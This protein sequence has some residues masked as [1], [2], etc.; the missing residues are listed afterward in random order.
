V[1][2]TVVL[3]HGAWHGAWCWEKVV[4]RL[5][6]AGVPA[7]AV[8]LPGH[9]KSAEPFGDLHDDAA[10]VRRLLDAAGGPV[11]LCG[12]SYGGMVITEAGDHPAV[13]HLV[14]LAAFM[15]D[16]GVALRGISRPPRPSGLSNAAVLGDDGLVRLG[17]GAAAAL[18]HDCDPADIEGALRRLGPHPAATFTQAPA[19]V[20]WHTVP[21]TYVVCTAD[22][23][24]PPDFQRAMAERAGRVVEWPTGHS[25]FFARP[26]LVAE[27][28]RGLALESG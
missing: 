21:S 18:Y 16:E 11:V 12:H 23:A 24:I 1:T 7:V 14:Y 2:A 26:D 6:A 27:L 9:G 20:A 17:P 15:P 5:Q 3:V 8:D 28:L 10:A 13:R 4:P 22:R 25:P 19:A